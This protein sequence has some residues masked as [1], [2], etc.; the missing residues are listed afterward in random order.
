MTDPSRPLIQR[1]KRIRMMEFAKDPGPLPFTTIRD[2]VKWAPRLAG[3]EVYEVIGVH[4]CRMPHQVLRIVSIE[5]Y[6]GPPP[7]NVASL[8]AGRKLIAITF[9]KL[10]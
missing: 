4:G 10:G 3:M 6:D 9:D 2:A 5:P 8:Y 1:R 7:S